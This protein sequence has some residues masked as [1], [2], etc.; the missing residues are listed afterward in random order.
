MAKL[1]VTFVT[2]TDK[3]TKNHEW[4]MDHADKTVTEDQAKKALQRLKQIDYLLKGNGEHV[5]VNIQEINAEILE[6]ASV[7]SISKV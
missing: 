4:V 5:A 2:K 6:E 1:K 3:G 7:L